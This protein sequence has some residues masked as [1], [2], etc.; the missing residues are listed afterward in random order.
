MSSSETGAQ[1][2]ERCKPHVPAALHGDLER[3]IS[4]DWEKLEDARQEVLEFA[5]S[6]NCSV[7]L[8]VFSR[9]NVASFN[10]TVRSFQAAT[11][12]TVN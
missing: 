8:A 6:L 7:Q 5:R 9:H 12:E 10:S 1:A 11:K 3:L 2:L 4:G